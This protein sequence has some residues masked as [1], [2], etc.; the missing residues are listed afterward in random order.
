[1]RSTAVILLLG[2]LL[3]AQDLPKRDPNQPLEFEPNLQL[4][5]VKPDP[6]AP[7]NGKVEPWATP[8]VPA[9]V[10]KSKSAAERARRK[11]ER[12]QKLQKSGV[13]SKVEAEQAIGAANRASVRYQQARIAQ[14]TAE[15]EALKQRASRGEA[16]ADLVQSA[17]SALETAKRLAEEA[18]G[19]AKQT[20]VEFAQNNLER[21]HKMAAAG[22]GS[23][24]QV[25]RA[26]A[27]L[28]QLK[29]K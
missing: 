7:G 27:K 28:E 20:E 9:D 10:E 23:K 11:A 24:R 1:M 5:D 6:K 13:L 4:Y 18:E 26:A 29:P 25:E 17:E 12:W 8:D 15:L 2:G 22:I 3:H 19:T 21:E 14:L 16:S